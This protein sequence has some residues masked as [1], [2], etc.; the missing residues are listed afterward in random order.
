M[1]KSRILWGL[2]LFAAAVFYVLTEG[3]AGFLLLALSLILPL[4]FLGLT[5]AAAGKLEASISAEVAGEKGKPMGAGLILENRSFFPL[6]RVV[7]T[8]RC[9]NLLT[10]ETFT[11]R[12]RMAAAPR[13]RSVQE[14]SFQ[15]AHCG[16]LRIEIKTLTAY[17]LFGIGRFRKRTEAECTALVRPRTFGMAAQVVYGESMSLDGEEYSMRKPGF[18]PSETFAI[19]EY[20][21]GDHIRQI[22]WKLSEK[23]GELTVRDY[24][25]PIQ[26]TVL[27]LLETG[28]VEG[29]SRDGLSER[30]D[31]LADGI[32]SLSQELAEQRVSH[33]LGWQDHRE[34]SFHCLEIDSQEDLAAALPQILGAAPGA[35]EVS[36]LGHYLERREQCEFAHV[37]LFAPRLI[38]DAAVIENQAL[39]TEVLCEREAGGSYGENN[40]K[41]LSST[42]ETLEEDMAYLE[43]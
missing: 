25:L 3:Y 28:F 38:S 14:L 23:M 4:L 39:V 41:V 36:V 37:V 29:E 32:L 27:L 7:C 16:K 24:G 19:R 31:A 26:N 10:G 35:D 30:L 8:V 5:W 11:S 9:E 12:V 15:S 17:D 20:R 18:D 21:P 1:I 40:V 43:L 22:H 13:S 34:G 6:D 33:S 42:A 2:W